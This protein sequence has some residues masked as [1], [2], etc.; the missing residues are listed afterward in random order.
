MSI[1]HPIPLPKPHRI[2]PALV[3]IPH[4]ENMQSPTQTILAMHGI[5][6]KPYSDKEFSTCQWQ[7]Q[8]TYHVGAWLRN[9]K[10]FFVIQP[11]NQLGLQPKNTHLVLGFVLMEYF[12][13]GLYEEFTYHVHNRIII[14]P[15]KRVPQGFLQW[16]RGQFNDFPRDNFMSF[17]PTILN[18]TIH[19]RWIRLQLSTLVIS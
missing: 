1:Q 13:K 10:G 16:Q 11:P 5:W 7:N 8:E 14:N 3:C 19:T 15:T 12:D 4:D 17:Q 9:I 2:S 6:S 18:S